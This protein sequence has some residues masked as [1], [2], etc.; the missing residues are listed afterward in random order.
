MQPLAENIWVDGALTPWA[1]AKIHVAN[2]APHHGAS[3]FEGWLEPM[4]APA[5]KRTPAYA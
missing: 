4:D 2:H 5:E 1:D 3:V